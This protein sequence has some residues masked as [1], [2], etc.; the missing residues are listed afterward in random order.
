MSIE[1]MFERLEYMALMMEIGRTVELINASPR[2]A[3]AIRLVLKTH[4][5]AQPNEPLTLEELQGM[6]DQPVWIKSPGVSND[7]SGR[8]V[9]VESVN[10]EERTVYT[11]GDFS[12]H[13]YGVVWLA[14]RRPPQEDRYEH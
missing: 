1:E 12:C 11:R 4:P 5:A 13:D 8:W 3:E 7:M 10:I 9:I 6:V 14:Y 2:Y